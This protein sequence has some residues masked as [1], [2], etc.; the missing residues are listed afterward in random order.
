MYTKLKGRIKNDNLMQILH[1]LCGNDRKNAIDISY[2]PEEAR[3]FYST[4]TSSFFAEKTGV[5]Y[6]LVYQILGE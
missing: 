5:K 6:W 1:G 2:L 3:V 4:K